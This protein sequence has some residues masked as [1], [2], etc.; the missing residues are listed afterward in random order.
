MIARSAYQGMEQRFEMME[1]IGL[2]QDNEQ[3]GQEIRL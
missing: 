3:E 1:R 2:T